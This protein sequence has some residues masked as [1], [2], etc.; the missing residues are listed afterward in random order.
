[1]RASFSPPSL[2]L[3]LAR[4]TPTQSVLCWALAN[5]AAVYLYSE[6]LWNTKIPATRALISRESRTRDCLSTEVGRDARRGLQLGR[7]ARRGL[8]GHRGP[9]QARLSLR[10]LRSSRRRTSQTLLRPNR[11]YTMHVSRIITTVPP[12]DVIPTCGRRVRQHRDVAH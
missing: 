12:T 5:L 9:A 10:S 2:A 6:R 8:Q 4:S 7:D 1:M 11:Q 3:P